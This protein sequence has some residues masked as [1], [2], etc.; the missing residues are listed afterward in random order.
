MTDTAASSP[1]LPAC[2]PKPTAPPTRAP[3][4]RLSANGHLP[5]GL[6][7]DRPHPEHAAA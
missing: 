5:A 6:G 2:W 7:E 1:P 4:G 3:P